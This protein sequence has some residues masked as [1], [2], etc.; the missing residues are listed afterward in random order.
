[1]LL[2]ARFPRVLVSLRK[3]GIGENQGKRPLCRS[4]THF[5]WG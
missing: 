5:V 2:H 4:A 3:T 1:M